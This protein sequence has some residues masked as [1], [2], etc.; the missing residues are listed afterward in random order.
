MK[1]FPNGRAFLLVNQQ[2]IILNILFNI[3]L[4]IGN[5]YKFK[6][7]DIQFVQYKIGCIL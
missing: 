7:I 6:S 1:A 5:K 2:G 4:I 3:M